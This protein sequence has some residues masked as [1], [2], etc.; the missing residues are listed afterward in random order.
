MQE[1]RRADLDP[2]AGHG[3]GEAEM[4]G[5]LP[6]G[7]GCRLVLALPPAESERAEWLRRQAQATWCSLAQTVQRVK[8]PFLIRQGDP[9]RK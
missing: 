9:D 8:D 1:E 7:S 6:L 5:K 3:L 4:F 2:G